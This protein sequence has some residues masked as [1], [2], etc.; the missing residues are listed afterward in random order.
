MGCTRRCLHYLAQDLVGYWGYPLIVTF[1]DLETTG[2]LTPE[3]RIIELSMRLC[4]YE[5]QKELR[6]YLRRYNPE[7]NIEAAAVKIHGI[8]NEDAKKEETFDVHLWEV[9]QILRD[10]DI[11]VAHN[12]IGFDLPYLKQEFARYGKEL[13]EFKVFDT[14][15]K[16]TS[17]TDL[18]KSP[19]LS[20]LCFALDV[21]YDPTRAHTGSYD[22]EVLRDSFFNAIKF[23]YFDLK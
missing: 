6:N 18:G 3:G 4:T 19:T 12:L 5:V 9:E 23:G 2:K 22:T 7:R 1:L 11:L 20:E 21:E 15:I 13:P 8:T 14:M 16:G 10:T 17:C